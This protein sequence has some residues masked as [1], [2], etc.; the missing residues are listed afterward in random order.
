MKKVIIE[1]NDASVQIG[2]SFE[3]IM[4]SPFIVNTHIGWL[5][6]QDEV[7][8]IIYFGGNGF[9]DGDFLVIPT[10]WIKDIKEI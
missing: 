3:D 6:H 5:K 9:E 10:G 7:K 1:W 4:E 2:E 8:T